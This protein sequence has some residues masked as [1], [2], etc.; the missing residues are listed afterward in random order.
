MSYNAIPIPVF[1]KQAKRLSKKFP[2]LKKELIELKQSLSKDPKQDIHLAN[3]CYK[4]RLAIKSKG[5]GKSGGARVVTHI[6]FTETSV[7][8]LTIYD[9]SDKANITDK[10]LKELLKY[11]YP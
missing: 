2:S 9:K 4:I 6:H 3:N 8:L 10:E 7:Y 5:R 1:Q 11:V